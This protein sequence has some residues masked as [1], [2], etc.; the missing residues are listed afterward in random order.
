M[1]TFRI[2][3]EISFG[4]AGARK[5]GQNAPH[6][7]PRQTCLLY[8]HQTVKCVEFDG[9][10][11]AYH[12]SEIQFITCTNT[13][14]FLR[15][16]I[17]IQLPPSSYY[18]FTT[19]KSADSDATGSYQIRRLRMQVTVDARGGGRYRDSGVVR[20]WPVLIGL[21]VVSVRLR[22]NEQP[23]N[24]ELG[25][26]RKQGC[27]STMSLHHVASSST[28]SSKQVSDRM[29]VP[30]IQYIDIPHQGRKRWRGG[31]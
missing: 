7:L 25:R 20:V 17:T 19:P 6:D 11:A 29:C 18:H 22:E 14:S 16:A 12:Q 23:S 1:H 30:R 26:A 13:R 24:C 2:W 10:N 15:P 21:Q 31:G 5:W 9:G 27:E 4:I 8:H 28:I 3:I